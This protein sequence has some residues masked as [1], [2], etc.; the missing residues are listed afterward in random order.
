MLLYGALI[1]GLQIACA[2]HCLRGKCTS[3]N[4]IWLILVFPLIGSLI[5]LL[6]EVFPHWGSPRRTNP[7]PLRYRPSEKEIQSERENYRKIPEIR[8]LEKQAEICLQSGQPLEAL[9]HLRACL[10]GP[11]ED[12]PELLYKLAEAA[13]QAR[14]F[15]QAQEALNKIRALSD[16]SPAKVRLLLAR[17][18]AAQGSNEKA[19]PL[20]EYLLAQ[21]PSPDVRYYWACFLHDQGQIN[22]AQNLWQELV[23]AFPIGSTAPVWLEEARSRLA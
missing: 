2:V 13:F 23:A 12:D 10:K 21:Y 20:F 1:V 17:S 3:R 5:Y 7:N 22:A 18:Y 14:E 19:K 11:C 8:S 6:A 16:Y 9:N 4:W 15:S